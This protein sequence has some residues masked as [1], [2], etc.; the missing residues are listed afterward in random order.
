MGRDLQKR[1]RRSSRAAVR[2]PSSKSKRLM[3]PLGNSIVAQNWDKKQT[4]SQNY[5]R[6]GLVNRLK[7]PTGGSE[8]DRKTKQSGLVSESTAVLTSRSTPLNSAAASSSKA[9]KSADPFS[10]ALATDAVVSEVRVERDENGKIIRILDD[11][12]SGSSKSKKNKTKP[13]PLNDPLNAFD[14]DDDEEGE[15]DEVDGEEWG[16]I[17]EQEEAELPEGNIIKQLEEEAN[18]PQIKVPRGQSAREREW[19]EDLV[20]KHGSNLAAMARDRKLN[21]MQQTAADIG[22]RLKKLRKEGVSI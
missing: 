4:A 18:R 8:P 9:S 12:T 15:E 21:P 17:E 14:S 2:Q 16:G 7:A 22:R 13:N 10:I 11:T 5:R 3:F 1:K 19:L 20:A 6:L